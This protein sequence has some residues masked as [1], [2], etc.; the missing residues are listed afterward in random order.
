M[1]KLRRFLFLFDGIKIRTKG[2]KLK[3]QKGT[4]AK[5]LWPRQKEI[6][7]LDDA[8]KKVLL[9]LKATLRKT[10]SVIR[11]DSTATRIYYNRY[12]DD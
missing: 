2:Q 6:G 8:T 9:D 4:R 1:Q 3:R 7:D 10:P 11:D 12:A 5:G